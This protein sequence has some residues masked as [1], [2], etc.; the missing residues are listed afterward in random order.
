MSSFS[1]AQEVSKRIALLPSFT[2][3]KDDYGEALNEVFNMAERLWMKNRIR[4]GFPKY[5]FTRSG[6]YTFSI[7]ITYKNYKVADEH[8]EEILQLFA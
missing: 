1:S 2:V 4:F 7:Y 3:P 6:N 5:I 8:S